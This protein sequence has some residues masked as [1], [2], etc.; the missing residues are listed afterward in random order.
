M[1]LLFIII[2]IKLLFVFCLILKCGQ[3]SETS[4]CGNVEETIVI[5]CQSKVSLLFLGALQDESNVWHWLG[6]LTRIYQSH[7]LASSTQPAEL[8]ISVGPFHW[9]WT[10]WAHLASKNWIWFDI[11]FMCILKAYFSHT[12]TLLV[13]HQQVGG[14]LWV[15][16]P[17]NKSESFKNIKCAPINKII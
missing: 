6:G 5:N 7:S 10:A 14:F 2:I 12:N 17:E 11:R 16:E 15:K 4:K 8:H 13:A 9:S 3:Q 1:K